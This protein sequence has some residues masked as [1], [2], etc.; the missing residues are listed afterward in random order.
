MCINTWEPNPLLVYTFMNPNTRNTIERGTLWLGKSVLALSK[1]YEPD[2]PPKRTKKIQVD[3][4]RT[5][6]RPKIHQYQATGLKSQK[7]RKVERVFDFLIAKLGAVH[8]SNCNV[9]FIISEKPL[10]GR[11]WVSNF[12]LSKWYCV[13]LSEIFQYNITKLLL[14][15]TQFNGRSV[16][17]A[18]PYALEGI[19][20]E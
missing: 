4:Y 13:G 19:A 18:L 7:I 15:R 5:Q 10:V 1:L 9:C 12:F 14:V 3:I 20:T 8:I 11:G 6:I 17:S 2:I 16:V